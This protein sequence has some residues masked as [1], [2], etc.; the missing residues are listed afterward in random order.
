MILI[1]MHLGGA[2]ET[3]NLCL[4][5][6]AVLAS[7]FVIVSYLIK[8]FVMKRQYNWM[9]WSTYN[10]A[11]HFLIMCGDTNMYPDWGTTMDDHRARALFMFAPKYYLHDPRIKSWLAEKWPVWE[12]N[13][14]SWFDEKFKASLHPSIIPKVD[15]IQSAGANQENAERITRNVPR[16][17]FS[18]ILAFIRHQNLEKQFER[19]LKEYSLREVSSST[20]MI[21]QYVSNVADESNSAQETQYEM[22]TVRRKSIVG[23]I[24]AIIGVNVAPDLH[25]TTSQDP[26][27]EKSNSPLISSEFAEVT[28]AEAMG[29]TKTWCQR[30]MRLLDSYSSADAAMSDFVFA[31][32]LDE[33]SDF[34]QFLHA[35][36]ESQRRLLHQAKFGLIVRCLFSAFVSYADYFSDILLAVYYFTEGEMVYCGVTIAWPLIVLFVILCLPGQT[37]NR[38]MLYLRRFRMKPL[39]DTHRFAAGEKIDINQLDPVVSMAIGRSFEMVFESIPQTGVQIVLILFAAFGKC[40]C[41]FEAVCYCCNIVAGSWIY[42]CKHRI[43]ISTRM[44]G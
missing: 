30:G 38:G 10:V 35:A 33:G 21:S 5:I 15:V 3:F 17:E 23:S 12:I 8:V 16:D 24:S 31:W 25:Q 20:P 11:R 43:M 39:I 36:K 18:L 41:R 44:N 9:W 4:K 14:P 2:N 28:F 19:E 42:R 7:I 27:K 29:T 6:V 34:V 32:R 13:P 37:V 22:S 26:S 40:R 1:S